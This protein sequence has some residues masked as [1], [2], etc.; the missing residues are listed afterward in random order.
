V[1]FKRKL[2][3]RDKGHFI[4]IKGTINQEVMT[5]IDLYTL[6]VGVPNFFKNTLIELKSH[7]VSNTVEW[8]TVIALYHQ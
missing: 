6:N 8:K 4:L 5:I 2:V 3:R 7:I 1:D